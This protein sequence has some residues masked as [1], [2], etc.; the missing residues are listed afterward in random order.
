M[1][2]L[3]E[4]RGL[5]SYALTHIKQ[6]LKEIFHRHLFFSFFFPSSSCC[7]ACQARLSAASPPT[8]LSFFPLQTWL[9]VLTEIAFSSSLS[10]VESVH[11]VLWGR[12]A[13]HQFPVTQNH[14][15]WQQ[16]AVTYIDRE[17]EGVASV[18]L[19]PGLWGIIAIHD[20][21]S[22]C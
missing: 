9:V 14:L 21:F 20:L 10:N 5:T 11:G 7:M 22:V 12:G 13:H 19:L 3:L 15:C 4:M 2:K 17:G 16:S 8:A 1:L 6:A 18:N